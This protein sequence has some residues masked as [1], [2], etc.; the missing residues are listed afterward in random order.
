MISKETKVIVKIYYNLEQIEKLKNNKVITFQK[1]KL[2][3]YKKLENV[4][5]RKDK[6]ENMNNQILIVQFKDY[7]N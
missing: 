5:P 4:A 3:E 2:I 1:E 7:Q 6:I